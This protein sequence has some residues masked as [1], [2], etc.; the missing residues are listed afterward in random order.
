MARVG[1]LYDQTIQLLKIE[2]LPNSR[3]P[4]EVHTPNGSPYPRELLQPFLAARGLNQCRSQC[5]R[6]HYRI[7]IIST[8]GTTSG[9]CMVSNQTMRFYLLSS[10]D[11]T[12]SIT[13][14]RPIIDKLTNKQEEQEMSENLSVEDASS[15]S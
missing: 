9:T 10:P 13:F 14:P 12:H 15:L 11:M 7:D 6:G 2:A 8:V 1:T 4:K 3:I 5:H